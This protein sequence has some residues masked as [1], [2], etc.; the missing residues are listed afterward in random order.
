MV[1]LKIEIQK[2]NDWVI[3]LGDIELV[4]MDREA[5]NELTDNS[6]VMAISC[7]V[8]LKVNNQIFNFQVKSFY[9]LSKFKSWY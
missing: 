8:T 4:F 2:L 3:A 5:L 9:S 1:I 6:D 7:F